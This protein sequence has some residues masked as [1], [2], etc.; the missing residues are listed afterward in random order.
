MGGRRDGNGER[1]ECEGCWGVVRVVG[2]RREEGY[3]SHCSWKRHCGGAL[4]IGCWLCFACVLSPL[5]GDVK[6]KNNMQGES[7][8]SI[9]I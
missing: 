6:L 3:G 2:L 8:C 5:E 4:K 7:N 9:E 1:G